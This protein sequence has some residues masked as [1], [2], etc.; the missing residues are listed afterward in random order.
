MSDAIVL[1]KDATRRAS[2]TAAAVPLPPIDGNFITLD[3]AE[4]KAIETGQYRGTTVVFSDDGV[5]WFAAWTP[6]G[7]SRT[8]PE[9]ARATVL[10]KADDGDIIE[11]VVVARWDE[12][13]PPTDG[14]TRPWWDAQPTNAIGKVAV[15]AALRSLFRD[16]IGDRYAREELEQKLAA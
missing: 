9:F 6:L 4:R 3:E 15:V 7:E 8:H 14:P 16:V 2:R 13:V 11:R 5:A 1:P 10:R 12:Y